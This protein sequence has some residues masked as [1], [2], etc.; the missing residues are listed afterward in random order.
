M[1]HSNEMT[2]HVHQQM[3]AC[4]PFALDSICSQEYAMHYTILSEFFS[5]FVLT[6]CIVYIVT[7]PD[8]FIILHSV[9]VR[10][11]IWL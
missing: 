3:S 8:G 9:S 10:S 2:L 1:N 6:V 4:N 7:F 5:V 11:A